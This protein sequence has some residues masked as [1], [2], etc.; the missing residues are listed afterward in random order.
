MTELVVVVV[1]IGIEHRCTC[2]WLDGGVICC[3]GTSDK[4]WE[5]L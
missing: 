1:A 4:N 3:T 5:W 2:S